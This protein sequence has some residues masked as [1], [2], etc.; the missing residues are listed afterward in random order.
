MVNLATIRIQ[1]FTVIRFNIRRWQEFCVKKF[2]FLHCWYTWKYTSFDYNIPAITQQFTSPA[3]TDLGGHVPISS[4]LPSVCRVSDHANLKRPSKLFKYS[5]HLVCVFTIT[6]KTLQHNKSF[7]LIIKP[8]MLQNMR[9]QLMRG[10]DW[11][12]Y[13]IMAYTKIFSKLTL[14]LFLTKMS[15]INQLL[16]CPMEKDC[17]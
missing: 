9:R 16:F 13:K 5:K 10:I 8:L 17:F 12:I 2:D 14:L 11:I 4:I 15:D 3:A 7:A 1:C 6:F